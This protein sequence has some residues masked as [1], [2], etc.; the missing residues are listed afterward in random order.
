M[1]SIDGLI[2]EKGAVT[3]D[4]TA[5][6]IAILLSV[7][8]VVDIGLLYQERRQ[9]Q[10][11][12]DAAALAAAI[13][14]AEGSSAAD[15]KAKA[16]QYVSDNANVAPQ[17]IEVVFPAVD[18]VRV[19]A[20]TERHVFFSGLVGKET[21]PVRAEST[22]AMGSAS[23]VA[24]LVPF[25]V[26]LQRVNDYLGE[27]RAGTFELGEDRPLEAF[28]KIQSVSGSTITY[29]ITYNNTGNKSE[30][31]SVRDPLPEGTVYING[32][33]ENGGTYDAST[34]E[35]TWDFA[36]VSP[37]DY[38]IMR[39]AVKV[40]SGS[41]G[42]VKNTAYLTTTSNGKTI[43]AD[44]GNSAQQ[45]YFWLCDF[46]NGGGTGVPQY[47]Q[48]IRKGYP[49]YV[50][51][52]SIANG[53]GVKSSLKDAMAWRQQT[54]PSIVVPVYGYT[55]GGGSKGEYKVVGFAEFVITGFSF[56]GQPKTISGY[57]T[58]GTVVSGVQGPAPE[59]Y[60]GVDTVWLVK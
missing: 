27:S 34:K 28:S 42:S 58:D 44:T 17:F 49:D 1:N 20:Q 50:Y 14:I 39:F 21:A 3:I 9:L 51:A 37:G 52:G 47:D 59:A 26:P 33:V 43:T 11:S 2:S 45:G 22:A 13:D 31:I 36:N 30:S 55:Q 23:G 53:T 7:A 18:R 16:V 6:L 54:D 10:T 5:A 15:A 25:V 24:K 35:V 57:F 12:T 29:T 41:V 40:T 60:F 8:V 46:S 48:W 4:V 19:V 38:R 56:S 32:S